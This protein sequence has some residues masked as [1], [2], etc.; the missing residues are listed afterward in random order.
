MIEVK[1]GD[2][3][4][5]HCHA[6]V[7]TVN[8][9][10]VMGKGV[11]AAFKKQYP[12]MFDD[13]AQ[14]CAR[15]E[16]RLGRPYVYDPGDGHLIV[17]FPTKDHWRAVSRL[18]AIVEGLR[19]LVA[20]YQE[21]GIRSIAVPPLGCGNGQLEWRVVGPTLHR[22]LSKLAIPVEL[23]APLGTPPDEM[24]LD[25]FNDPDALLGPREGSFVEAAWLA[26][27]EVVHRIDQRRYHWPVGHVRFQKIAYFLAALGLPMKLTYVRGSYG[28]YS[29]GLKP[30]TARL[31]NNGLL[32]ERRLGRMIEMQVGPTFPDARTAYGNDLAQW[33]PAIEKVTD[34]FARMRTDQAEV[35]ASVHLVT[36][37]LKARLGRAPTEVE[38]RDEVL[39]WKARRRPPLD[40]ATVEAAITTLAILDWIQVEVSPELHENDDE[41][42]LVS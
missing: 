20:H 31:L 22:E 2:L 13:Y 19:Y 37:E 32:V 33:E 8:C 27:A 28:P 39:M 7:N 24:Q 41:A 15:H 3:L 14:R 23:F 29:S 16:V 35:A 30:A 36:D 1:T 9:V 11:A 38:V 18:D 6:L 12:K 25:F 34:L 42:V 21:W 4:K 26:L 5:S 40:A 10:G 17:N